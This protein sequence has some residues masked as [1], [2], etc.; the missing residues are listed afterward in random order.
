MN[1][2]FYRDGFSTTRNLEVEF[3]KNIGSILVEDLEIV[4]G[5]G[6]RTVVNTSG[7]FIKRAE[8]IDARWKSGNK[9]V[10]KTF[11]GTS[12]YIIQDIVDE[13]ESLG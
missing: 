13:L 12:S 11:S 7:K 6:E 2:T 10:E 5:M 4:D 9:R 8:I 3:F 1:I